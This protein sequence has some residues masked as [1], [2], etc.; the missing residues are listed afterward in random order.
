MLRFLITLA[1][2]F[3]VTQFYS[4]AKANFKLCLAVSAALRYPQ[5]AGFPLNAALPL[6]EVIRLPQ[7]L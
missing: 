7:P 1:A 3:R 6:R 4:L 2:S 5:T